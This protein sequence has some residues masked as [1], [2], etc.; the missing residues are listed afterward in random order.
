[1]GTDARR[2]LH[3]AELTGVG[4]RLGGRRVGR[5]R[6]RVEFIVV[7]RILLILHRSHCPSRHCEWFLL[8]Y[9]TSEFIVNSFSVMN[10]TTFTL[11]VLSRPISGRQA[12]RKHP[13][14]PCCRPARP[15]P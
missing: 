12:Y 4:H 6:G 13:P 9:F 8:F 15:A 10:R 7:V 14:D 5:L 11:A 2:A 1:V 3:I